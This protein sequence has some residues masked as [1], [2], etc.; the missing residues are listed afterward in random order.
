LAESFEVLSREQPEAYARMCASLESLAVMLKVDEEQFAVGFSAQR[1]HVLAA[2]GS[3]S[4]KVHTR[5]RTVLEV[6]EARRELTEA[7]YA[8]AVEVV[9]SLET[10]LQLHE[11]LLFYVRG[12]VRSPGFIPLLRRLRSAKSPEA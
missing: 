1:A 8:D 3:E 5:R 7:V 12:A 2:T 6:L 10:L 11:G 9:G 4:A